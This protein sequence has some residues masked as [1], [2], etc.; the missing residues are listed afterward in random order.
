MISFFFKK[1]KHHR[2]L[3]TGSGEEPRQ[4]A[5]LEL[6][7]H[8]ALRSNAEEYHSYVID[9]ITKIIAMQIQRLECGSD[10]SGGNSTANSS[11]YLLERSCDIFWM[12]SCPPVGTIFDEEER[13]DDLSFYCARLKDALYNEQL[14][15]LFTPASFKQMFKQISFNATK[16]SPKV[17]IYISS[18]L[19]FLLYLS[20][21][22]YIYVYI[23]VYIITNVGLLS[24]SI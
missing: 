17:Y 22:I 21:Y 11:E 19:L 2:T 5:L 8:A 3:C 10:S 12:F 20:A 13:Q 14:A 24:G 7:A 1:K 18:N 15:S 23:Y 9:L 6:Q 4:K 16:F